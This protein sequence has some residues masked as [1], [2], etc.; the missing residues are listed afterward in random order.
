LR[1]VFSDLDRVLAG[2]IR[3]QLALAAL[4]L[5]AYTV[6]LEIMQ[7]PY[8][9]VLGVM[10]GIMEFIPVVGPLVAAITILGV[11]FLSNY[12]HLLIVALFL[13]AWRLM[14]DYVNA[15]RIMAGSLELHPLTAIFAVL[16][17][18]EIA[19]VLGV[20]LSIPIVAAL[21]ILWRRWEAFSGEATIT[22]VGV[23]D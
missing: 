19:G 18:G 23:G 14:Q 5:V 12:P 22:G 3:A 11:A 17:G 2:Y 9:I 21:R 4:S 13:G 1:D 16:V 6:V 7:V 10:A 8:P 15:P 20:F